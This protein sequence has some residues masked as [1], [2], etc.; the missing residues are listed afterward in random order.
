MCVS[1]FFFSISPITESIPFIHSQTH[2]HPSIRS[3][4]KKKKKRVI[5]SFCNRRHDTKTQATKPT[6]SSV[7]TLRARSALN[8]RG[9]GERAHDVR[10]CTQVPFSRSRLS[11][12]MLFSI[13]SS[14][15]FMPLCLRCFLIQ[16]HAAEQIKSSDRKRYLREQRKMNVA[17]A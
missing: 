4:L 8:A 6:L 10:T 3:Q 1:P 2:R 15:S 14:H 17:P 16:G 9:G 12:V 7:L 11:H 13:C 5:R